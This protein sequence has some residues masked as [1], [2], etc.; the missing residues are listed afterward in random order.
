LVVF[1]ALAGTVK[2]KMKS[3]GKGLEWNAYDKLK[4]RGQKIFFDL[5]VV[6]VG[7][8][9]TATRCDAKG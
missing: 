9:D 8:S 7:G 5:P 6:G 1:F 4:E 2:M 3:N